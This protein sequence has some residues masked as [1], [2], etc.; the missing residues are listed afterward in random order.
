LGV[1][2]GAGHL[3][4]GGLTLQ[5]PFPY[6][7]G[8]SRVAEEVWS[9]LGQVQNYVE[10]FAGSLAVL[11]AGPHEPKVET[12][13][14]K[15]GFIAN[16][17]RAVAHA[18]AEVARHADWPVSEADLEARH[19]WL[20]TE[21]AKRLAG[22]LGE[23]DGCDPQVA[24]WWLWG[25]CAWIGSGWCSGDGP[26]RWNGAAWKKGTAG[27]GIN[28]QL[29]HLG[30]A[31]QGINRQ[32]PHL[33]DA[34]RGINR[35]LPHLGDAGRG[36]MDWMVA[37][38]AR[39][40]RVRICCGD[41]DR[42]CGPS[43]TVKNGLTG[44]FLDPP[45]S[46]SGRAEVYRRD[47]FK[48]ALAARKWAIEAGRQ[49]E[50][51]IAFCGYEGEFPQP[52]PEGW[53]EYQWKAKGGHAGQ[54]DGDNVNAT[55]E[56]VWFSPHCL[57]DRASDLFSLVR[58]LPHGQEPEAGEVVEPLRGHHGHYSRLAVSGRSSE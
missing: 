24:G 31:G 2:L 19:Y 57:T 20:V 8:K 17:W 32:L 39:L 14:D 55:R 5:A 53:S 58:Y 1:V 42:V 12:V 16:F 43:V 11:L 6:F 10:P 23:P 13:N 56:R 26:W 21:G 25:C 51:R 22:I 47:D 52:W 40:R 15:D 46:A 34:G 38:G 28:R 9:R 35:Q 50:M 48:V 7:G 49:L 3:E 4:P 29:P 54:G 30:T 45:Y 18:P 27:Q 44:V 36:I 33:G 37:L 41:W